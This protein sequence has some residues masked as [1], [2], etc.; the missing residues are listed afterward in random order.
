MST[1]LQALAEAR[2]LV[3]TFGFNGFS[4]QHIADRLGIKKPSLY[5]HFESKEALGLELIKSYRS[6]FER[7]TEIVSEF[8]PGPQVGA[9]FELYYK[10]ACDDY[11]Q[12]PLLAMTTEF[13]SLPK[14]MKKALAETGAFQRDWLIGVIARGQKTK[15]FRRDLSSPE[16]AHAIL[17]MS[18]GS[19][20]FGRVGRNPES[21]RAIK[22][23]ALT[24]LEPV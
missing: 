22:K 5:A 2:S 3:Q 1:R 16:L 13:N 24:L 4:F 8:E 23:A 17:S 7:W 11:K 19:Q 10:F 21:I 14:S 12:C 20:A 9:L 6:E 15:E 18:Y